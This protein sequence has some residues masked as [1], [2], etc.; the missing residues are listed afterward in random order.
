MKAGNID[1]FYE[2]RSLRSQLAHQ[3]GVASDVKKEKYF[4]I[5]RIEELEKE[6]RLLKIAMVKTI[7]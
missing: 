3:K 6:V 2:V 4:L 7:D 5:K 1:V